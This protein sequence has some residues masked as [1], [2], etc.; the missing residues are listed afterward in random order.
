[1]NKQKETQMKLNPVS[2]RTETLQHKMI[3]I[4]SGWKRS[5]LLGE[6]PAALLLRLIF[7]SGDDMILYVENPKD[8]QKIARIDP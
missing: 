4:L 7:P 6:R 1:M 3:H 5:C 8:H 2:H